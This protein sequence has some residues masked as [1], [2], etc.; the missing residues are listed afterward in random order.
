[1]CL[2]SGRFDHPSRFDAGR[3]DQYLLNLPPL[4]G[5]HA[6]QVGVE[7]AVGDIVGMADMV[8]LDGFFTA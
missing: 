3:T 2:E 8:T 5:P 7:A 4:D 1:M 6:L